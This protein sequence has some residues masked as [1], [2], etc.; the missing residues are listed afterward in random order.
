M[1]SITYPGNLQLIIMGD[2]ANSPK[3][4]ALPEYVIATRSEKYCFCS[5]RLSKFYIEEAIKQSIVFRN[6]V[7]ANPA[8]E[9]AGPK[10][11]TH[12]R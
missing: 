5:L 8:G 7:N 10:S 4:Y 1:A 9:V 2:F 12:K 11:A 3:S 6:T